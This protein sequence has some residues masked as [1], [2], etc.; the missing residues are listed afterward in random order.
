MLLLKYH[1]DILFGPYA[2]LTKD[3]KTNNMR[4]HISLQ[5]SDYKLILDATVFCILYPG[6]V[7]LFVG[8][9][10]KSGREQKFP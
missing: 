4:L 5:F 8:C 9:H 1:A 10:A 7:V 2:L 6:Q 3:M